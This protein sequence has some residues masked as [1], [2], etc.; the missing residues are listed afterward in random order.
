MKILFPDEIECLMGLQPTK[1]HPLEILG[2]DCSSEGARRFRAEQPSFLPQV[3]AH[4]QGSLAKI[5]GFPRAY[6]PGEYE[7][8]TFIQADGAG[9]RVSY[10]VEAGCSLEKRMLTDPMS[11]FQAARDYVLRVVNA[12]YVF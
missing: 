11:D 8:R 4:V 9:F 3:V 1:L 12:D 2:Y 10:M 5:G 7:C 6:L